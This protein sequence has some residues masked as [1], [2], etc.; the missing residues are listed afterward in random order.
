M[1]ADEVGPLHVALHHPERVSRL[2]LIVPGHIQFPSDANVDRADYAKLQERTYAAL[3]DVASES[4]RARLE[5]LM[6]DPSVVTDELVDVRAKLYGSPEGNQAM[7]TYYGLTHSEEGHV[8]DFSGEE[9]QGLTM[10]T[11]VLWSLGG[12]GVAPER[13]EW[14][15]SVVPNVTYRAIEGTGHWPQWERPEAHD[16]AIIEFMGQ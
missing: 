9:L 4:I 5:W 3:D 14:L 15:R 10:P 16:N 13:G 2:V 6:V 7:R 8:F 1:Q 11:L 12:S